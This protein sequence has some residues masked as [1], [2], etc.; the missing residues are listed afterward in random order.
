MGDKEKDIKEFIFAPSGT[1]QE[2]RD[3]VE[4]IRVAID[5]LYKTVSELREAGLTRRKTVIALLN[6]IAPGLYYLEETRGWD[7][8]GFS[9][10][11]ITEWKKEDDRQAKIREERRQRQGS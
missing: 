1:T 10:Q 8:I 5:T 2:E 9:T 4:Q 11:F 6:I 7:P 3:E